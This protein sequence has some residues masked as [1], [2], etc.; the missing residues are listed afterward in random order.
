MRDIV[1]I[2]NAQSRKHAVIY[3]S[4]MSL[5]DAY[6]LIQLRAKRAIAAERGSCSAGELDAIR[7]MAEACVRT[8]LTFAQVVP[9]GQTDCLHALSL[10][11]VH[12]DFEDDLI[13][14]A[15][16]RAGADY[17]VSSDERLRRHAPVVCLTPAEAAALLRD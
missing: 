14:A 6:Y 16:A 12:S 8:F 11:P 9:T 1:Q 7:C 13:I 15:V 2:L 10:A 5:K 4:A 17:L 3:T